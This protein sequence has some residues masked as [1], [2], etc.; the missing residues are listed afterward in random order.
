[1]ASL[2]AKGDYAQHIHVY[3]KGG[4]GMK[5]PSRCPFNE[6]PCPAVVEDPDWDCPLTIQRN[7]HSAPTCVLYE[8]TAQI[9]RIADYIYSIENK[10]KTG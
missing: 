10:I 3:P 7:E 6:K 8:L 9:M 1:M 5:K 4:S 2:T